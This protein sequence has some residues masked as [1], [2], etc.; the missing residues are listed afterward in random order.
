MTR[1]SPVPRVAGVYAWYFDEVPTGIDASEC[2]W[3]DGKALLY[4]G[5][6]PSAPPN[7]GGPPS[8]SQLNRRLRTHFGGNATGSTLRL[9]L[10]CLLSEELGIELRRVGR[11]GRYTFT[12]PG[13]QI[14]DRWMDEHAFVAWFPCQR[15][16]EVE[17]EI[18]RSGLSLPLNLAGNPAAHHVEYLSTLRRS[19]RARANELPL[20]LDNGGLRGSRRDHRA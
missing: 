16:W 11:T 9:T 7:N 1:P 15:A 14:L 2:H 19:A 4:V 10:G 12:N 18:L 6:S 5:I 8:R 3:S 13:E 17:D 20:I